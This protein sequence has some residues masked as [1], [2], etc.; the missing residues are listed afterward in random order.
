MFDG[1]S[2]AV[3]F[4]LIAFVVISLTG[5]VPSAR[6][7]TK[8]SFLKEKA[9]DVLML[10]Y[11]NGDGRAFRALLPEL[12]QKNI[13][14]HLIVFGPAEELFAKSP[15][16]TQL[17]ERV[18]PEQARLWRDNRNASLPVSLM[19]ELT[20]TYQPKIVLSGMAHT[21]Q[22]ELTQSWWNLGAWTIAFYDNL[23]APQGQQW[24]AP[25]LQQPP[26]LEQLLVS[27]P[28][29]IDSFPENYSRHGTLAVQ[30]PAFQEWKESFQR[31]NTADL[32]KTLELD[33]RPVVL[34]AG[35]YGDDFQR[36]FALMKEAAALRSDIQWLMTP[37]PRTLADLNTGTDMP[38]DSIRTI[39]NISTVRLSTVAQLVMT[40]RST[41]GWM[42]SQ[43][44]LPVIFVRPEGHQDALAW[45]QV[46]LVNNSSSLLNAVHRLLDNPASRTPFPANNHSPTIADILIQRLQPQLVQPVTVESLEENNDPEPPKHRSRF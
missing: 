26:E 18:S 43:T 45:G 42:A 41:V 44:G 23:E 7:A 16:I 9:V 22:T 46:R 32:R 5:C 28:L 14:W 20:E 35:G 17:N 13:S 25:W 29:L 31:E 1:V 37:H 33:N 24:I 6:K 12:E 4:L 11:D 39:S 30:H 10:A 8:T 38:A 2:F 40:H 21:G 19:R 27:S 34:I 36:S 15:D 3:L